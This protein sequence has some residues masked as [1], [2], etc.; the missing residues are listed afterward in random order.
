MKIVKIEGR[1]ELHIIGTRELLSDNEIK[2]I[3]LENDV[4]KYSS[5]VYEVFRHS[6]VNS[7]FKH[8]A[9]QLNY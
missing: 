5:K 2:R 6:R 9:Y 1:N 8:F 3:A 7:G 4:Q